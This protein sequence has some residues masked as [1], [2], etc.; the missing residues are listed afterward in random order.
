MAP[1]RFGEHLGARSPNLN[2]TERPL[3]I[4]TSYALT[5]REWV[6][7]TARLRPVTLVYDSL[8]AAALLAFGVWESNLAYLLVFWALSVFVL[9]SYLWVPWVAG[10]VSGTL[11]RATSPTDLL[12][13]GTGVTALAANGPALMEWGAVKNVKEIGSCLA[14][15]RHSGS[16]R[17][18]PKG[19]FSA[20]QLAEL[21]TYLKTEGLLDDRSLW[22]KIQKV[23]NEGPD[24]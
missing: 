16:W 15:V 22:A 19:A 9:T 14:F 7:A 8:A 3:K 17:I 24:S 23:A 21:R 6:W 4:R 1:V 20:E 13:D 2:S 18:V 5:A 12:I 11:R 10:I